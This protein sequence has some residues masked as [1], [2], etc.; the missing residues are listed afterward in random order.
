MFR[1]VKESW[2]L[3]TTQEAKEEDLIMTKMMMMMI[4]DKTSRMGF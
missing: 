1:T 4:S 2:E 3:G